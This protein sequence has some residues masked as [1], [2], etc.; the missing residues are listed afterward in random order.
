MELWL[1][2]SIG[3]LGEFDH[4]S[5]SAI[6]EWLRGWHMPHTAI[7]DPDAQTSSSIFVGVVESNEMPE[8]SPVRSGAPF[9]TLTTHFLRMCSRIGDIFPIFAALIAKNP[10]AYEAHTMRHACI[11]HIDQSIASDKEFVEFVDRNRDATF[12]A[13]MTAAAV[14]WA[15]AHEMAHTV[16]SKEERREAFKQAVALWPDLENE[17]WKPKRNQLADFNESLSRYRDEIACDMLAN[18]YVLASP[19][20]SDDL[21]TQVS[22]SLLALEAL[23]WDGL[24]QDR[25]DISD[26]HPSPT[27]RFKLIW[28]AWLETLTDSDTWINRD[29]PGRLGLDDFAHWFAFEQW[30]SGAYGAHRD[31]AV[32]DD[33]IQ[34]ARNVLSGHGIP[35][36][37]DRIYVRNDDGLF[38]ISDQYR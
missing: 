18:Q 30:A 34:S 2:E 13:R 4:A 7:V 38:R 3:D 31:G 10:D 12:T 29:A 1:R 16:S 33:D 24:F 11:E 37:V 32:W 8:T 27:L 20:A 5:T 14:R 6:D 26:T 25:S 15:I 21:M 35:V 9:V 22:G 17:Q 28:R 23:R 36:S 19:F